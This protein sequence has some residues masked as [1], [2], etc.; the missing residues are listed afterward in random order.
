MRILLVGTSG[1]AVGYVDLLLKG[2]ENAELVGAVDPYIENSPRKKALEDAKIP[3]YEN[4]QEFY[5][6]DKADLAIICTP[7]HLH[8]EMSRYALSKGSYVLCEK[9][10]AA[11]ESDALAMLS[12]EKEYSRFI[13]I[14]YQWSYSDAIKSLKSD[15]IS[16][17]FGK[18]LSMKSAISWPRNTDYYNRG[19]KWAGR[20]TK[21]G[22]MILDSVAS[23]ACAHYIHNMLF[24][25]GDKMSESALPTDVK[26]D[27]VRANDIE[28][29][30]TCSL[31]I[32]TDKGV[33]LYFIASH[34]TDK[35]KDPEFVYEFEKAS[36]VYA[37]ND[38]KDIRA[39]YKDGRVESYKD[40]FERPLG[41]VDDCIS[42]VKEGTTPICTVGTALAHTRLIEM[43]YAN[44]PVRNFNRELVFYNSDKRAFY[45]QTL[46]EKMYECYKKEKLLSELYPDILGD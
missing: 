9:P 43:I 23:N 21:D 3:I 10:A 5:K 25:L 11:T 12:A 30:D 6:A 28:N 7:T 15:I 39:V 31:R 2:H 29:F 38:R 8:S 18:A 24:L 32:M 41:K 16:G 33:P 34:A 13:A 22:R 20:V 26:G 1:Y 40:P 14:G 19:S 4:M 42:A 27:C 36:I 35:N 37:Q 17:K 44:I 45:V 46:F